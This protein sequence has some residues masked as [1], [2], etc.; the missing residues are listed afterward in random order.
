MKKSRCRICT[1]QNTELLLPTYSSP[2]GDRLPD[3]YKSAMAQKKIKIN[4]LICKECGH[5]QLEKNWSLRKIHSQYLYR[6]AN[7][8]K[9][10]EIYKILVD[11]IVNNL[12]KKNDNNILDIGS[13]DGSLLELFKE[14]EIDGIG[15][16]PNSVRLIDSMENRNKYINKYFENLSNFRIR[17]LSKKN[18]KFIFCNFTL[19]N[20]DNLNKFLKKLYL[21]GTDES[22]YIVFTGYHPKQFRNL[23][24]DYISHDHLN[25][26]TVDTFNLLISNHKFHLK[27]FNFIDFRKGCV[28]FTFEKTSNSEITK[29]EL[30]EMTFDEVVRNYSKFKNQIQYLNNYLRMLD[31]GC[32][33]SGIGAGTSTAYLLSHLDQ[34]LLSY[35]EKIYDDDQRKIGRYISHFGIPI[36]DLLKL[37]NAESIVI[38]LSWQHTDVITERLKQVGFKGELV[39]PLPTFKVLKFE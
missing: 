14:H 24:Y 23:M 9:L 6:T 35:F 30:T 25:Y 10:F 36:E 32:K 21:I 2:I 16:D 4:V 1:S 28:I 5:I 19:A 39:V 13:G 3:T 38:L 17:K 34:N 7:T 12:D 37:T 27:S 31:G 29:I 22:T 15:I 18:F 20:V 33:V 26:F 11:K 8:K